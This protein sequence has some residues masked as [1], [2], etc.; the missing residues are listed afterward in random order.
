MDQKLQ[1]DDE[2]DIETQREDWTLFFV[3][4]PKTLKN[5]KTTHLAQYTYF[6]NWPLCAKTI[7]GL[8][9]FGIMQAKQHGIWIVHDVGTDLNQ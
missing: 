5:H 1:L 7:F 3:Q 6:H 2:S 8:K 9:Y 4:P